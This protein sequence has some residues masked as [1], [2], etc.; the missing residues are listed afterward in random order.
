M[1]PRPSAINPV[2]R[3]KAPPPPLRPD[4]QEFREACTADA[5]N[6]ARKAPVVLALAMTVEAFW[7]FGDPRPLLLLSAL[8]ITVAGFVIQLW[9]AF[10]PD[11]PVRPAAVLL[12][13]WAMIMQNVLL[14]VVLAPASELANSLIMLSVAGAAIGALVMVRWLMVLTLAATTAIHT[15]IRVWFDLPGDIGSALIPGFVLTFALLIFST[16]QASIREALT[17]LTLPGARITLDARGWHCA[18]LQQPV[19]GHHPRRRGCSTGARR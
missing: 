1:S 10:R 13:L 18:S 6:V 15:G 16:R 3:G 17:M 2:A 19:A 12:A 5:R 9:L 7:H 4:P 14:H 8:A 11:A